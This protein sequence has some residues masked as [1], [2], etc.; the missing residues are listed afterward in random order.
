MASKS[1]VDCILLS[2]IME[3]ISSVP[4]CGVHY[5]WHPGWQFHHGDTVQIVMVS[6]HRNSLDLE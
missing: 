5:L 4:Y 1:F 6:S 2:I 3:Y